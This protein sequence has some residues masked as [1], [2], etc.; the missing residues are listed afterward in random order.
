MTK[1]SIYLVLDIVITTLGVCLC[2]LTVY[3]LLINELNVFLT[4]VG[5]GG[6][7]FTTFGIVLLI[8]YHDLQ[9]KLRKR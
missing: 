6:A 3:F 5:F 2:C 9:S 7:L 1:L 8:Q 4:L